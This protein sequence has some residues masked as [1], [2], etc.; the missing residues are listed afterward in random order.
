MGLGDK[1]KLIGFPELS[2]LKLTLYKEIIQ[3]QSS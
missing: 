2:I 3:K 1:H